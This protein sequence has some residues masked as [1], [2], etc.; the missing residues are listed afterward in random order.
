MT[1][2]GDY[3]FDSDSKL[4]QV[5]LPDTLTSIGSHAFDAAGLTGITI[6]SA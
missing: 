1:T 4:T 6:P 5:T 2:I 3:A